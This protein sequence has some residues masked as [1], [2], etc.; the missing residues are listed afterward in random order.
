MNVVVLCGGT[1][2]ERDVSITSGT[3]ICKAL[4][5]RNHEV[6]LL[7]VYLGIDDYN[8]NNVFELAEAGLKAAPGVN[9]TAPDISQI[10]KSR[11]NP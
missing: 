10:K 6:V 8:E 9:E 3:L 2:S 11:K 5:E 7:D 4:K 1:S